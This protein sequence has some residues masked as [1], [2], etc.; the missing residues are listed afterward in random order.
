MIKAW[1]GRNSFRKS[2]LQASDY[3]CCIT[4]IKYL[5]SLVASRIKPWSICSPEERIDIHNTLCLNSLHYSLFNRYLMTID[6]DG[7]IIYSSG[8]K[9]RFGNDF[10]E[11][12]LLK[13]DKIAVMDNNVPYS[14]YV[15]YHNSR[16]EEETGDSV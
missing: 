16:F 5:P 10:F 14:K 6:D 3:K 9:K 12:S 11:S 4:G 8:L 7:Y 2:V 15:K 13:Y 1:M